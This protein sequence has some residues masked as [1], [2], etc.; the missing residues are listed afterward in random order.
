MCKLEEKGLKMPLLHKMPLHLNRPRDLVTVQMA[1]KPENQRSVLNVHHPLSPTA[2]RPE[3]SIA[4]FQSVQVPH[5]RA[6]GPPGARRCCCPAL[7]SWPRPL[8]AGVAGR[9]GLCSVFTLP[10]EQPR[11]RWDPGPARC[12]LQ[13]SSG[14]V[15]LYMQRSSCRVL[16]AATAPYVRA[17]CPNWKSPELDDALS[18]LSPHPSRAPRPL[19]YLEVPDLV[20]KCLHLLRHRSGD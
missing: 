13:N 7:F 3:R 8:S 12:P 15:K 6:P 4:H 17:L 16:D 20:P 1:R 5:R 9:P 14:H 19:W 2:R 11:G 10:V 18:E